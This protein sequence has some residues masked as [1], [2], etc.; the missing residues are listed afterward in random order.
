MNAGDNHSSTSSRQ[1]ISLWGMMRLWIASKTRHFL[2]VSP[3]GDPF[4]ILKV[5]TRSYARHPQSSVLEDTYFSINIRTLI[6]IIFYYNLE[7]NFLT[8]TKSRGE[9]AMLADGVSIIYGTLKTVAWR[10]HMRHLIKKSYSFV[11]G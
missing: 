1:S 6:E 11:F 9:S 8:R 3:S 5:Q 10:K 4:C 7:N 2:A